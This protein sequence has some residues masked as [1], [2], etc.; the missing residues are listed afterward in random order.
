[1]S[2]LFYQLFVI[3]RSKSMSK[4][5]REIQHWPHVANPTLFVAV[6]TPLL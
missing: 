5:K 3:K 6:A 2:L 1:M 4:F